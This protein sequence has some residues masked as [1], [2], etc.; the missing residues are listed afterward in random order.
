[1]FSE[2][3]VK[4]IYEAVAF[5]TDE[6]EAKA[7][8]L[9]TSN[10]QLVAKLINSHGDIYDLIQ[11]M[12]DD[13]IVDNSNFDY[14]AFITHGWAAPLNEDGEVDGAP[15]KHPQKRRVRLTIGIDVNTVQIGSALKFSDEDE[16][17]ID[18]GQATGMLN[19]AIVSLFE[20]S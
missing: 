17:I 6:I 1:M 8:G 7:Y 15:S 5:D 2:D 4:E 13:R 10:G 11:G 20:E 19:D 14:I 3:T 16:I 12:Y 9:T 18:M